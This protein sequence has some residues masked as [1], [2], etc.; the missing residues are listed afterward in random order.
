[1][2]ARRATLIGE[3][4]MSEYSAYLIDG[5]GIVTGVKSVHSENDEE[6]LKS[7]HQLLSRPAF[8]ALNSGTMCNTSARST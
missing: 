8:L 1:M 3:A 4:E 6:A 5:A 2:W 7:A